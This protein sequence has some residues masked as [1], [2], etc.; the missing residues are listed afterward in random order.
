MG[1]WPDQK[2]SAGGQI[3]VRVRDERVRR[4]P[5][6]KSAGELTEHCST[7]RRTP[8]RCRRI[9]A[10]DV[11][12]AALYTASKEQSSSSRRV[13]SMRAGILPYAAGTR[14]RQGQDHIAFDRNGDLQPRSVR[15]F[16]L[17][18]GRW[19]FLSTIHP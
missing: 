9:E 17:S 3:R 16:A 14:Y 13:E 15:V 12:L 11:A 1:H 8:L 5:S 7:S 6:A 18:A 2:F 19:H 10:A 4:G